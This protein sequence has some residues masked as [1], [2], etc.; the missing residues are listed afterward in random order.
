MLC[1]SYLKNEETLGIVWLTKVRELY[2]KKQFQAENYQLICL[3]D[4][5]EKELLYSNSDRKAV[6]KELDLILGKLCINLTDTQALMERL[7]AEKETALKK[8]KEEEIA[9][10]KAV[11]EAELERL[12]RELSELK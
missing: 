2:I 4:N 12:Q 6:E 7:K 5:G 1:Y 3:Y 10:A 8:A 9:R 11:K